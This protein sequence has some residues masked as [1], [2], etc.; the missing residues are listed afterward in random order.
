MTIEN[1][2]KSKGVT[3]LTKTDGWLDKYVISKNGKK[4]IAIR[5]KSI[6]PKDF[7]PKVVP[8]EGEEEKALPKKKGK[9][10]G[11]KKKKPKKVTPTPKK[12]VPKAKP[13]VKPKKEEK[14]GF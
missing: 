2:M 3:N 10:K 12:V 11:K 8:S 4:Y 6:T 14:G 13:K 9:K 7:F 1:L 5:S